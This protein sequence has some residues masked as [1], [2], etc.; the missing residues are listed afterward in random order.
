MTGHERFRQI[1]SDEGSCAL[2][3]GGVTLRE[4]LLKG[5]DDCGPGHPELNG[6]FAR[7][8]QLHPGTKCAR[9]DRRSQLQIN[10]AEHRRICRAVHF[11]R[12]KLGPALS[13][14]HDS[15]SKPMRTNRTAWIDCM[16]PSVSR[17]SDLIL[18]SKASPSRRRLASRRMSAGDDCAS[19]HPSRRIAGAM[20]LRMRSGEFKPAHVIQSIASSGKA[21]W[22]ASWVSSG[23]LRRTTFFLSCF[24]SQRKLKCTLVRTATATAT[25]SG[26]N[27]ELT[28]DPARRPSHVG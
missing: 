23:P 17:L 10:L 14:L 22:Y 4:Q 13:A 16:K 20:L 25:R 6:E 21:K 26:R 18:G 3:P 12:K 11:E 19:R 15:R 2:P 9:Q 8:R 1:R 24:G 7:R 5:R 27:H 28:S